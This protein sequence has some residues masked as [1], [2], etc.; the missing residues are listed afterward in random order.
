MMHSF[1]VKQGTLCAFCRHWNDPG[2]IAISPLNAAGG[3]WQYNDQIWN[4]CKRT[5][6][7][8]RSGMRCR[9]YE[10]KI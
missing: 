7:K 2:G 4:V 5:G 6:L 8:M 10:C 1:N 3:A 9:Y